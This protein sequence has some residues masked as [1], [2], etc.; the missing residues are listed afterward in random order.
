MQILLND[1]KIKKS[2]AKVDK[3]VLLTALELFANYGFSKKRISE[4]KV[5]EVYDGTNVKPD[6]VIDSKKGPV[7]TT[8][9]LAGI[10]TQYINNLI[11]DL[12]SV[13][14]DTF[15][16]PGYV[17]VKGQKQLQRHVPLYTNYD[18][19]NDLKK[20]AIKEFNK[21]LA[22]D[23][24]DLDVR[25]NKIAASIGKSTRTVKTSLGIPTDRREPKPKK[26]VNEI[27]NLLKSNVPSEPDPWRFVKIWDE[28][29]VLP[30][31]IALDEESVKKLIT[32]SFDIIKSAETD[33]EKAFSNE[34]PIKYPFILDLR[35]RVKEI[36]KDL[37]KKK[38]EREENKIL[39]EKPAERPND[40]EVKIV[41]E[42]Q[43]ILPDKFQPNEEMVNKEIEE[44][45][46]DIQR[47]KKEVPSEK[48]QQW[49]D[50]EASMQA[51]LLK[52]EEDDE[53]KKEADI[54][55]RL[56]EQSN[57][58]Q[59]IN[60]P[61]DTSLEEKRKRIEYIKEQEK[62]NALVLPI[63]VST[64]DIFKHTVLHFHEATNNP[65][66]SS[67]IL[68]KASELIRH[69]ALYCHEVTELSIG[70][71]IK[72]KYHKDFINEII[73]TD[74]IIDEIE[75]LPMEYPK[76]CN[77]LSVPLTNESKGV[78]RDEIELL[79]NT[80][81]SYF[82]KF[83]VNMPLFPLRLSLLNYKKNPTKQFKASLQ[84]RNMDILKRQLKKMKLLTTR[85]YNY[86]RE[87]VICQYCTGLIKNGLP[88]Q[89]VIQ[90]VQRFAR[91]SNKKYAEQII[92]KIQ[93][94]S[95]Q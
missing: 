15:L 31:I 7:K 19:L 44:L 51:F 3:N 56:N 70:N 47:V 52:K 69:T 42:T 88:I 77:K 78:I 49:E 87:E 89:D 80:D 83:S 73:Q 91:Y 71:V 35:D 11:K 59:H 23:G 1:E 75:P 46:A 25:I 30:E 95:A 36:E 94:H 38:G 82:E 76:G 10:L 17:D 50:R 43:F 67:A 45:F 27:Y 8:T 24:K 84:N 6:I 74:W 16:F 61:Q 32:I 54:E 60:F 12:H 81:R 93:T 2:R 22:D 85:G 26:V 39:E 29:V 65:P 62:Y 90:L 34:A 72:T 21:Q 66:D 63:R 57:R 9:G 53:N 33:G 86:L 28:I 40:K 37:I 13:E 55:K 18:D 64:N 79:Q 14:S 48:W 58:S 4:I 20:E 5:G 68:Q 41:T 92:N